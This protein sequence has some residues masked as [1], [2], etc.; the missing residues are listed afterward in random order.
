VS[1]LYAFVAA[2]LFGCG[3]YMV[4]S[5]HLVRVLLG[6][7]LLTTAVN[8]VL[9][10]AGR[11]GSAQPPLIPD[12]AD[13]LE[14]SADPLP[15]ALVLTAIVIGFALSVILAALT[16][17]A[18]RGHGTLVSDEIRSAEGLGDPFAD[19]AGDDR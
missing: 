12:G 3:L 17:G 14:H 13:R 19:Q 18:Y 16:L 5:R 4:L 11:I 6:L 15:Q 9:F 1:V 8:L 7:S 10:Q 2:A